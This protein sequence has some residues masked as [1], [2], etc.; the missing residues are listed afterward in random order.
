[1]NVFSRTFVTVLAFLAASVSAEPFRIESPQTYSGTLPCADCEGTRVTL[2]LFPDGV[3]ITRDEYLGKNRSLVDVGRWTSAED[4]KL[5][6]RGGTE[7]PTF[8]RPAGSN[9]LRRL[10]REG[11]EICSELNYELKRQPEFRLISDPFRVGGLFSHLADAGRMTICLIAQNLPVAQEGDNAAV[12]KAYVE[13]RTAPGA[14][15][16]VTFTGHFVER[17]RPDGKTRQLTLVVE[18]FERAWPGEP[19]KPPLPGEVVP[20]APTTPEGRTWKLASLFGKGIDAPDNRRSAHLVFDPGR[21]RISGSSGCNKLNGRYA[22]DGDQLRFSE[23]MTT[24]VGCPG[25]GELE[26]SF[27]DALGQTT[28]FKISGNRLVLYEGRNAIA[29]LREIDFD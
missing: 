22:L 9:A 18:K 28:G 5:T 17:P 13:K 1:V 20:A 11:N 7:A 16:F 24:R 4:G 8:Y 26:K 12:E 15:L 25:G 29:E 6:L 2:D 14:P 3:F 27:L 10:D 21:H 19:C 23:V